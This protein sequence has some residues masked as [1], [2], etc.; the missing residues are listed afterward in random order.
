MHPHGETIEHLR[1]K[2]DGGTGHLDNKA[3]ACLECNSGR[4][5]MDWLTYKSWKCGEITAQEAYALSM[6]LRPALFIAA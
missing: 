2:I 3:L 4:G 1:R 5:D 6:A